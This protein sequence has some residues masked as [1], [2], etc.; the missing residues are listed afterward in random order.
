MTA[1]DY[2][3]LKTFALRYAAAEKVNELI[4]RHDRW[5]DTPEAV[6]CAAQDLAAEAE[7]LAANV[8]ASVALDYVKAME[9][10]G[11]DD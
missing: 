3:A 7:Q 1:P 6:I 8:L 9:E 4:H 10:L 2:K 11:N 5:G